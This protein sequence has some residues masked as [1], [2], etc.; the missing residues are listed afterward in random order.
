M[1][2]TIVKEGT[3]YAQ[4]ETGPASAWPNYKVT[5]PDGELSGKLFL[6]DQLGLT[7]CEISFNAMEPG[8]EMPFS[9]SHQKN[10]EV[11][12]IIGG[13]G[14]LQVDGDILDVQE[15]SIVRIAPQAERA[16]RNNSD[17]LLTYIILQVQQGSLQQYSFGDGVLAEQPPVW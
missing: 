4:V 13:K 17:Q 10:E 5:L 9:H 8:A 3:N 6:K 7:G 15:G 14:Q 16:W 2:S 1:Q 12:I 11:Y